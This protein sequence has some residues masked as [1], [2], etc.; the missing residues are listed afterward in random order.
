MHCPNLEHNTAKKPWVASQGLYYQKGV[1]K[2][3]RAISGDERSHGYYTEGLA[4]SQAIYQ[5]K[6]ADLSQVPGESATSLLAISGLVQ[7]D[8]WLVLMMAIEEDN[9]S[10]V[11]AKTENDLQHV[12]SISPAVKLP[13]ESAYITKTSYIL[14]QLKQWRP[15]CI[16]TF[17]YRGMLIVK[18]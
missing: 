5:T 7:S 13:V 8:E 1:A 9:A 10:P 3:L 4:L 6:R 18:F 15:A 11:N 12:I 2:Q 14:S 17:N 16:K